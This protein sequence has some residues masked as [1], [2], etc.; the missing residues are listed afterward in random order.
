MAIAIKAEPRIPSPKLGI[1]Y[2]QFSTSL[3]YTFVMSEAKP[4][5][6]VESAYAEFMTHW[7]EFSK[8]RANINEAE[9][10]LKVI[11]TVLFDVLDWGKNE[12]EVEKYCREVGFADYVLSPFDTITLVLEAKRAGIPF[13]VPEAKFKTEPVGFGLLEAECKEA[14]LSLRQALGYAASLG[15]RYIAVTNG[16]QWLFALTYV[17][18][19]SVEE[20]QV[21]V[22]DSLES[23]RDNFRRF[24]SCFG[25]VPIS[26][27]EVYPLLLESRKKPA[28][29]K[30]SSSIPGYP[31]PSSRNRFV[32]ELSYILNIVWD[33]LSRTENTQLFLDSCYVA[34]VANNHLIVFAKDVLK[35]R[36]DADKL[37]SNTEIANA[38]AEELKDAIIG[39]G[40][41]KPFVVL[42][43]VGHGKTTFLNYLRVVEAKKLFLNYIQ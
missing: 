32:N 40:N 20:R 38:K 8:L 1:N 2:F 22:F 11:N 3:L 15:S 34:P 5:W 18:S 31:V 42:G 25:K 24:W 6:T 26:T 19:Q 39:Y 36:I 21:I 29:S 10:R 28:P 7:D 14:G 12:V 41:E 35:R 4:T 17:Q 27:N 23:V 37:A 9:T 30:I 33:V 13:T 43:E 16:N